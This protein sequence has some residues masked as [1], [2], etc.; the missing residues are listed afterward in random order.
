ME[1]DKGED[2]TLQTTQTSQTCAASSDLCLIRKIFGILEHL[3]NHL[4]FLARRWNSNKTA[5]F[6]FLTL[7][8]PQKNA[9]PPPDT[10]QDDVSVKINLLKGDTAQLVDRALKCLGCGLGLERREGRF[11]QKAGQPGRDGE[12]RL[13]SETTPHASDRVSGLCLATVRPRW[14]EQRHGSMIDGE[15][16]EVEVTRRSPGGSQK[17]TPSSGDPGVHR[18]VTQ[19]DGPE[20]WSSDYEFTQA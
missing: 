11:L 15:G 10:P 6:S 19:G 14:G 18:R 9:R 17:H 7:G 4:A 16:G 1:S 12:M 20:G 8:L 3:K 13:C 2:E 5:D